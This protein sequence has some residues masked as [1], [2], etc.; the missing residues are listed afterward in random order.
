[1]SQCGC[2]SEPC[3]DTCAESYETAPSCKAEL[4]EFYLCAYRFRGT[5][6]DGDGLYVEATCSAEAA[7]LSTCIGTPWGAFSDPTISC[8]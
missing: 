7:A 8:P 6:C 3:F 1:M 5:I 2:V 4:D